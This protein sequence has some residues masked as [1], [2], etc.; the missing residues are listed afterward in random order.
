M[1]VFREP[2]IDEVSQ[3]VHVRVDDVDAHHVRA[4]ERG[5]TILQPPATYPYGER[6]YTAADLPAI[7]GR[8]RSRWTT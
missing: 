5:A 8:S 6:Q 3:L 2:R 1:A 4:V 7:D